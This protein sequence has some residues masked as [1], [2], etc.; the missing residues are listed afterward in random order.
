MVNV[1]HLGE[2]FTFTRDVNVFRMSAISGISIIT[3][4]NQP[5]LCS[6][7]IHII[8]MNWQAGCSRSW[9]IP[10]PSCWENT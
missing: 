4:V 6:S 7:T 9:R 5:G 10:R 2:E 3:T 1:G 8:H